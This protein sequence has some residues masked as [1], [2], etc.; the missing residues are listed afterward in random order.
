MLFNTL[1]YDEHSS[2]KIKCLW[3]LCVLLFTERFIDEF[4]KENQAAFEGALALNMGQILSIPFVLIGI[5]MMLRSRKISPGA[6]KK[7][8][9]GTIKD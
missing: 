8:N 4:F 7:L 2:I 5:F 1:K 3:S 6:Y 9:T